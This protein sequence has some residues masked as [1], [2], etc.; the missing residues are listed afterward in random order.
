MARNQKTETIRTRFRGYAITFGAAMI[1]A[2]AGLGLVQQHRVQHGLAREARGLDSVANSLEEKIRQ[3]TKTETTLRSPQVLA[4]KLKEIGSTLAPIQATQ[5]LYLSRKIP[6][7][8]AQGPN[9]SSPAPLMVSETIPRSSLVASEW[10]AAPFVDVNKSIPSKGRD[11]SRP[12]RSRFVIA[13][14]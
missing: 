10:V 14:R 13:G 5:R 2:A 11:A 9:A 12:S 8:P 6:V 7:L 1:V 4:Q 3:A